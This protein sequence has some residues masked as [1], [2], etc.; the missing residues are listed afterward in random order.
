MKTSN[1]I[2]STFTVV[3]ISSNPVMASTLIMNDFDGDDTND[4]GG[5]FVPVSNNLEDM[6]MTNPSVGLIS[7]QDD[8]SSN[9]AVGFTSSTAAD[10]SS[11]G[12][13]TIEWTVASGFNTADIRS[14]GWFL[15]VQ[16]AVGVNNSSAT[17]WNNDPDAVGVTLFRSG[18]AT[19]AEFAE[20]F[21]VN[22]NGENFVSVGSINNTVVEDGFTISL[23]LNSD[24][25][26]SVSSTGL[27]AGSGELSGSGVLASGSGLYATFADS[28]FA[29]SVVQIN[30][31]PTGV[32]SGGQFTS[33]TVTAIPEPSSLALLSLAA[34]AGSVRRRR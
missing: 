13:F 2:L 8:G 18:G 22:G 28:L 11:F 31:V 27:D 14:N 17:L 30:S 25:T 16:D 21:A 29:S 20:S 3:A 4:L 33:V 24:D 6:D 12:G 10:F 32:V 7:F 1:F 9:P 26:W 5:V 34:L 19:A 23:T 15:G